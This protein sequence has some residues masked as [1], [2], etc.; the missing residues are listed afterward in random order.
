VP[1]GGPA[2]VLDADIGVTGVAGGGPAGVPVPAD[3]KAGVMGGGPAGVPPA[4][5]SLGDCGGSSARRGKPGVE[6]CRCPGAGVNG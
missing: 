4:G 3:R 1:G 2:G 5:P 6:G